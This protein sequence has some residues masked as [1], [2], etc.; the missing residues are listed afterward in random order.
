MR[1]GTEP[2]TTRSVLSG[3]PPGDAAAAAAVAVAA[4]LQKQPLPPGFR[5]VGS[6][7][8]EEPRVG[9]TRRSLPGAR[10]PPPGIPIA[11]GVPWL[12]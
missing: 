2:L 8:T 4:A 12:L 11:N 6:L 1:G 3:A 7:D 5:M 10:S 9:L